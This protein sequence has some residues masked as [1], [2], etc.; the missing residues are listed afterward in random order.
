MTFV[1]RGGAPPRPDRPHRVRPRFRR[2][3]PRPESALTSPMRRKS[4]TKLV[5]SITSGA[6]ATSSACCSSCAITLIS[7][8]GCPSLRSSTR[9]RT[10]RVMTA[11]ADARQAGNRPPPGLDTVR[12]RRRLAGSNARV[13][14]RRRRTSASERF[15]REQARHRGIGRVASRISQD[16]VD[17]RYRVSTD[18]T[19]RTQS[20]MRLPIA[21]GS[22]RQPSPWAS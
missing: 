21:I 20:T 22:I 8:F 11:P 2:A 7:R 9:I 18:P 16:Y 19:T 4:S 14:S 5:A 15:L 3:I 6:S 10:W 17:R 1:D 12:A 13:G